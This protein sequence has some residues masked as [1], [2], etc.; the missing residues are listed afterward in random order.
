MITGLSPRHFAPTAAHTGFDPDQGGVPVATGTPRFYLP[1]LGLLLGVC[2]GLHY[3]N[4]LPPVGL[5]AFLGY[6]WGLAAAQ[7]LPALAL[8]PAPSADA[9]QP[10]FLSSATPVNPREQ[11]HDNR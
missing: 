6:L 5:G 10:P 1:W 2:L 11:E 7:V 9:G 4:T 8:R 3:G